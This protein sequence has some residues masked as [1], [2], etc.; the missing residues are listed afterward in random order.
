MLEYTPYLLCSNT[1]P[2][3]TSN[4]RIIVWMFPANERRCYNV[5]SS[6]IGWVHYQNDPC[7]CYQHFWTTREYSEYLLKQLAFKS[8][9]W[10]IVLKRCCWAWMNYWWNWFSGLKTETSGFQWVCGHYH[11]SGVIMGTMAS[12]IT[13]LTNVYSTVYSGADQRK[14]QNSASLA[15]VRGIHRDRWIPSTN[16]Q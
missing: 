9:R 5:T 3:I 4:A 6:L 14:H 2:N 12:Q 11:Y 13:S 7:G 8:R 16:G 1:W 15:F 10:Y